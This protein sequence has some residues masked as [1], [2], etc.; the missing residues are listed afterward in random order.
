MLDT[1]LA[2]TLL[3]AVPNDMHVLFVGDVDQLPSVGAGNVLRDVIASGQVPVAGLDQIFRQAGDSGIVTNAHRINKGESPITRGLPDFFFLPEDDPA[4]LAE[5]VVE[6]ARERLPRR[7]DF[8]PRRDIQVLCPMHGGVIGVSALNERLQEALNPPG[9]AK[10]E[11]SVGSRLYREGDRVIC[12]HNDYDRQVFNGDGGWIERLDPIEQEVLVRLDDDRRVGWTFSDLD[13]LV[14]AY[15]VT[16][17]KSQGSEYRAVIIPL[18]TAHYLM[19]QRNLLY[20]AVTRARELVV[21]VGSWRALMIALKSDRVAE[22]YTSLAQR[23]RAELEPARRVR[24]V[25]APGGAKRG[26]A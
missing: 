4:A 5:R 11:K 25:R 10:R 23:L 15:A 2:N 22:R 18:H 20:T 16:V 8:D 26:V 6:L 7:Y 3:K 1:L 14:L 19:L 21:L 24:P 13:D 12:I 9:P 17:H